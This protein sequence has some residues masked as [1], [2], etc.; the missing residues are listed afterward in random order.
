MR[1]SC[2][3]RRCLVKRNW[4]QNIWIWTKWVQP[5]E[6]SIFWIP[7]EIRCSRSCCFR[8]GSCCRTTHDYA[9]ISR[10]PNESVR[11]FANRY[12]HV[13][14]DLSAIGISTAAMYDSDSRGNRL[15]DRSRFTGVRSSAWVLELSVSGFQTKSTC[16]GFRQ[17]QPQEQVR[18]QVPLLRLHLRHL[19]RALRKR[20]LHLPP[21]YLP[22]RDHIQKR[23]YQADQVEEMEQIPE[24]LAEQDQQ[25]SEQEYQDAE[26]YAEWRWR[27]RWRAQW[28]TR[29]WPRR[30]W[31]CLSASRTSQ[32][33]DRDFEEVAADVA[34]DGVLGR[35]FT[36]RP[37]TIL[38]RR[39]SWWIFLGN[40]FKINYQ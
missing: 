40:H 1:H 37:R 18:D 2:C 13:E 24:E 22:Q 7:F 20:H 25:A 29:C 31:R 27:T 4:K 10:Y 12:A 39:L 23:V 33:A 15:L 38:S 3:L 36:G 9:H 14:K 19:L 35:K 30:W 21:I 11:Q 16:C 8:R 34:A 17:H 28:T 26:E 5:T 32:C 6:S